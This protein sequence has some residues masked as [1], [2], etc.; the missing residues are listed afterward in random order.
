MT[1]RT[2]G[3]AWVI[4]WVAILISG[5]PLMAQI[6]DGKELVKARLVVDRNPVKPGEK[7]RLGVVYEMEPGWHIY[8]KYAGDAGIPPQIDWQLPPGFKAGPLNWPLPVRDKEAGDLEVFT[9]PGQ[10]LLWAEVEA[11]KDLAAGPKPLKATS[12]WLVCKESCVPGQADLTLNLNSPQTPADPTLF[13]QYASHVPTALPQQYEVKAQRT[14][15]DI[16]IQTTG[17]P[18][19]T[20]LDFFPVPK[21]GVTLGHAKQ[22]GARII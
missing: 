2:S 10:T 3:L 18:A 1:Q 9:Y 20:V 12:K 15:K 5:S 6:Q 17:F 16:V 4:C 19:G 8:W 21:T 7:F 14:G 11:P 13:D 22:D